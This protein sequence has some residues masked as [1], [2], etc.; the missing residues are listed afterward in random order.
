N[1]VPHSTLART[2]VYRGAADALVAAIGEPSF[3]RRMQVRCTVPELNTEMD[4]YRVGTMLE[5]VREMVLG[6]ADSGL[7]VKVCI[8]GS[9]GEGIFTGLP[10]SLS[11][12]RTIME[13]M[14][15][16]EGY[17]AGEGESAGKQVGP[18]F[19]DEKDDVVMVLAPQSIVGASIYG[20]LSAMEAAATGAGKAFVLVNPI[21]KDRPSSAGIMGVR[22]RGD[23]LAFA[24]SFTDAYHFRLLYP[25]SASYYPIVG[26]VIKRGPWEP[27]VVFARREGEG[28]GTEEYTP[29]ATYERDPGGDQLSPLFGQ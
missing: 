2:F 16:G 24:A 23:R 21:L 6:L 7:R 17:Y 27:Y 20:P 26:A 28:G 12:M 13:R 8:Q 22:G 1:D 9:M 14:D 11:G 10:L 15:W 18:E 25:S 5:L 3:P 4:T 29:I 19:V